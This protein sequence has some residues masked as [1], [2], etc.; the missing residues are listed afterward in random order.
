MAR[1]FA[2]RADAGRRLAERLGAYAGRGDVIVLGLPRGGVP[3]AAEVA[4]SLPAP[5]DVCVVR[6]LGVPG[7]EELALGAIAA[8]GVLVLND[9]VVSGLHL[10]DEAIA[11][12]AAVERAELRRREQ[13]YRGERPPADVAGRTVIVVDDG[14]AT[15]ATMRAAVRA[16]RMR[17]PARVVVAVPVAAPE[18][19]AALGPEVDEVVCALRPSDFR[20]VGGW[21]DDFAPTTDDEVRR[22][23]TSFVSSS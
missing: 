22:C 23:V 8:G 2:D 12:V 19:C 6:K 7:D 18:T 1:E 21:Y 15:G 4:R 11:A 20:S 3:V 5:L 16:V 10:S 17:A 13:A 14:L 9:R